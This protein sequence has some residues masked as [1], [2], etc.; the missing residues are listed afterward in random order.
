MSSMNRIRPGPRDRVV[1]MDETMDNPP[2]AITS[3]T[4]YQEFVFG[5]PPGIRTQNLRIKSPLL[6]H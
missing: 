4:I 5:A 1:Q 2:L 6:C 3:T